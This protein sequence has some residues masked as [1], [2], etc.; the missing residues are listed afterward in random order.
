MTFRSCCDASTK[1]SI[2]VYC[3]D[4]SNLGDLYSPMVCHQGDLSTHH[5]LHDHDS[6]STDLV[7]R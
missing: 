6:M 1:Q 5:S 7:K 3:S 4:E 2:P